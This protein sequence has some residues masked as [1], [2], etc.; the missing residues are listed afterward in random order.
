MKIS[1]IGIIA[2][3]A[4]LQWIVC[5][6]MSL[7][8][9]TPQPRRGRRTSETIFA[10]SSG[11][12]AATWLVVFG[13]A[14]PSKPKAAATKASVSGSGGT[15]VAIE[16]GMSSA[17]V[18]AKAGKPDET[19]SDEETRGPGATVRIYRDGRCAVHMLGDKVEF[20]D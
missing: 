7:T 4:L 16:R 13:L 11:V 9:R 1:I 6:A 18:L 20:V 2:A 5:A 15:C 8:S 10:A 3:A 14:L 19:R 17:D 12:F